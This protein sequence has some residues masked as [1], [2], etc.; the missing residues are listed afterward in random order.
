PSPS[1]SASSSMAEVK[2][3]T[4]PSPVAPSAT[5]TA[6]TAS[7]TS[8]AA[9]A[10]AQSATSASSTEPP[11]V[12]QLQ[13]FIC[14]FWVVILYLYSLA[15]TDAKVFICHFRGTFQDVRLNSGS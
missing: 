10:P 9:Q 4:E 15:R 5:T 12:S 6:A 8:S 3:Q 2:P 11:A 13:T 14:C 7:A 1:V